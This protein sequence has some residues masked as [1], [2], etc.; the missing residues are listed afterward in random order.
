MTNA[1]P[2][3][4]LRARKVTKTFGRGDRAVH[5]VRPTDLDVVP[6][7]PIGI[8]GESGSGKSTLLRLLLDLEI[9][10]DG[11]VEF[12]GRPILSLDGATYR[13]YRS[14]VQAVFQD[15]GS[16]LDPRMPI[17]K[18]IT[19]PRWI[20]DGLSR[21]ERRALASELLAGVDLPDT[22]ADRL[23]HQLSGGERQRVCVARALAPSPVV[24]LLDEPVTALDVSVRGAIINLLADHADAVTYVVVSHDLT[25][26]AHL[27]EQLIIMYAGYVVEQ[28]PTRDVLDQ[29]L[30]PYTQ[31]LVAS[32]EDP[33]Y[34][35]GRDSDAPAPDGACPF[36]LRCPHAFD[37][38]HQM[39]ATTGGQHQ[40]RCHLDDRPPTTS[41]PN[42]IR[43]GDPR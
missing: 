27:T 10:S 39:P 9:P 28:G 40:V 25:V 42:L 43:A 29:P 15:P 30:H 16:S 37:A 26:I 18:S 6:G 38:C 23:P 21:D 24:V 36:L 11:T 12:E 22:F 35:G 1:V 31:A 5:A 19:E 14:S 33:L 13:K 41:T 17:W 2:V 3:A 4:T 34:A 32:V 8:A 20:R 7:R